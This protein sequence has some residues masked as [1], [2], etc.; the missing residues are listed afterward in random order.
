MLHQLGWGM[1][2]L[3]RTMCIRLV[4]TVPFARFEFALGVGVNYLVAVLLELDAAHGTGVVILGAL[5]N[6][7]HHFWQKVP[8]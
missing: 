1:R 5:P 7:D 2:Q 4:V 6:V 8:S 3:G